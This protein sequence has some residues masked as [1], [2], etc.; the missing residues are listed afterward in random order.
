M[1]AFLLIFLVVVVVVFFNTN[2]GDGGGAF[3]IDNNQGV[4][5]T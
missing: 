4:I 2:L 3:Q 1:I 5:R